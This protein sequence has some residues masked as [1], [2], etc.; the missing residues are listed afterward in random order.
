[1][2]QAPDAALLSAAPALL[3]ERRRLA[4]LPVGAA[5]WV[6]A[7]GLRPPAW[8]VVADPDELE[9]LVRVL[10]FHA[11]PGVRVLPFPGDDLPPYSGVAPHPRRVAQRLT[12]LDA[13]A[14]G[15]PI[16]AVAPVE[17]LAVLAMEPGVLD[18]AV[19]ELTAGTC[20]AR[21]E[22]QRRLDLLGYQVAVLVEDPGTFAVRGGVVDVWPAGHDQ[23]LRLDFFDDELERIERFDPETQ[24]SGAKV[25]TLRLLPARELVPDAAAV[26]RLAVH[27]RSSA[28]ERDAAALRRR[29]MDTLRNH[30]SFAG[31]EDWLPALHP[32]CS[33]LEH[34]PG[35]ELA[36]IDPDAVALALRAWLRKARHRY[37]ELGPDERP[38]VSP[39]ERFDSATELLGRLARGCALL[40]VA[41]EGPDGGAVS[42]DA[43][44]NEDLVVSRG[45]L[46]PVIERLHA[47]LDEGWRVGIT[48]RGSAGAERLR[49]LLQPHGLGLADAASR[50]LSA[51][52][53]GEL[54][55]LLGDLPVGF[56]A[57]E[58]QLALISGDELLGKRRGAAGRRKHHAFR[59]SQAVGLG[60]V[61]EG[62]LVVH[63]WHGIG[64]FLGMARIDLSGAGSPSDFLLLE[65]RGGDKLYVPVHKLDLLSRYRPAS[66]AKDPRLDKLGGV[67]W[68][69]RRRKVRDAMLRTAHELLKIYAQR[70]VVTRD[71][72]HPSSSWLLRFDAAFPYEETEDQR[73][74][75]RDVEK[76]LLAGEPM[77]RLLVGD[78][79]FGKTEV[80][81]RA[82]ARVIASGKQVAVLCPTTVLAYQHSET[83]QERF[84]GFPVRVA[85]L[86]R[87]TGA[88]EAKEV[89]AQAKAGKIDLL[90][91]TTKLLGRGIGFADLGLMV[92]DEEHR[93]GVRQKERIKRLRT[94]IDV[95]SLS[96]TPIPRTLS[97]ALSG[98]RAF[99]TI[100]TPPAERLAV[101]T[102]IARFDEDVIRDEIMKELG[103]GG[104]VFF[105][106]DRVRSIDSI[107]AQ[108][109][110]LVP[111]ARVEITHGQLPPPELE[112]ALV[113]FVRR[114]A[115]VLV[116]TSIIESGVDLPNVNCVIINRA[117]NFGLAQLY[118]IRGRVGR[119]WRRG[120]CVL[121]VPADV[122]LSRKATRRLRVLLEHQDLGSGFQVASADLEHRGAG[123][124][125][126]DN[127]HGHVD[128]V[129]FDTY[130]ELLEEVLAEARGELH[131]KRLDP[132]VEVPVPA[133]IPESLV[134]GV[135]D[136]L[137]EYRYLSAAESPSQ[138]RSLLDGMEDR[139]G[140]L[141]MELIN[142][143]WLLDTRLRCRELGVA[144]V[145]WLKVR[146]ELRIDASSQMDPKR[147][148]ALVLRL[149]NRF[150]M[151]E[152]DL[153]R[154]R[155]S[156]EEAEYPFRFLHWLLTLLQEE[157]VVV[158]QP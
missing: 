6:L 14:R 32:V 127:Q 29:V 103:R 131:R 141:P 99:S 152:D 67:S 63:A 7:R 106:H 112:A 44:G 133:F 42:F 83:W 104:Q 57:K 149:P 158:A 39:E 13:V 48:A 82:A 61:R 76:D 93:F 98:V 59:K 12:V 1:V 23:P 143:G 19:L 16:L 86:S 84:E 28:Q 51:L 10:A 129:G 134:P 72:Y 101:R 144:R 52:S 130:V 9:R 69:G 116:T 20:I 156:A 22:L 139:Y 151:P 17:A 77:D 75:I 25:D 114:Q 27:T 110:A 11:P 153:L 34:G 38:L 124:L 47:W 74:A 3:L 55:L 120:R 49:A 89:A 70:R 65:Y 118:Q 33:P 15:E 90:I 135:E 88:K 81:M 146:A 50:D 80:A 40:P 94:E 97:M 132:E 36:V 91:G 62:D 102:R 150:A 78:V 64:R 157:T 24:R 4:G 96:A 142:L 85:M 109:R 60:K 54:G 108:V 105:V 136:R 119:S 58:E 46:G 115:E 73:Q 45:D 43:L 53:P 126:G 128:A 95:L 87:F 21:K 155:F 5:G 145:S 30:L 123:T 138:L 107:A 68:Q 113:R 125:L 26:Q 100:A 148:A 18:Q 147:L 71:P 111:E 122:G 92:I 41:I 56:R 31:I 121:L 8:V 35:A 2:S 66:D 154:V 37:E 137:T 79:G 140:E 117:D